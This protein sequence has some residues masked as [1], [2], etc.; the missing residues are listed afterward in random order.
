[1]SMEIVRDT[2]TSQRSQAERQTLVEGA[3]RRTHAPRRRMVS[4]GGEEKKSGGSKKE[5][6]Q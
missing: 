3:Q 1:M 6:Q 4:G 5:A 2:I